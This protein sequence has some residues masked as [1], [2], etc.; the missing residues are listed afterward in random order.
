MTAIISPCGLYRY[1]LSR[2]LTFRGNASGTVLF[3]MLNPST[4][5]ADADDPTIRKC[6]SYAVGWGYARLEVV[7]LFAWR[8]TNPLALASHT[9][10]EASGP[11]NDGH[12]REAITNANILVGAWGDG[13]GAR[14]ARMVEERRRRFR[15]IAEGNDHRFYRLG[16]LTK[17]GNPRH[18]LYLRGDLRPELMP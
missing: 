5:D 8:A 4:A 2:D 10:A 7:N 13:K 16:P 14:V 18:P 9:I 12:I 15:E 17:A 11:Y 6:M 1:H 3:V